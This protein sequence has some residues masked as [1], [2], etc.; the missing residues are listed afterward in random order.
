MKKRRQAL[1][2]VVESDQIRSD[3]GNN[4]VKQDKKRG[5]YGLVREPH[6]I[7]SM[8]VRIKEKREE[9]SK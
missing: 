8:Y 6:V 3:A 9:K 4:Y 7:E 2:E 5:N 1:I